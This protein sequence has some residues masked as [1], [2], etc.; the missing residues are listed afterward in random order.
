MTY[1]ELI[2]QQVGSFLRERADRSD[3]ALAE[4]VNRSF[5]DSF[6]GPGLFG[7]AT[8]DRI[9][10]WLNNGLRQACETAGNAGRTVW[11]ILADPESAHDAE[12]VALVVGFLATTFTHLRHWP[13][14]ELTALAILAIRII[15]RQ[16]KPPK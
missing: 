15:S 8:Q 3:A 12:R 1:A 2:E 6:S 11:Q 10:H 5:V 9:I 4:E 14:H 7:G 13:L 16:V